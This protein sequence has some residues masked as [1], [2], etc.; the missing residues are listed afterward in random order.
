[1][2]TAGLYILAVMNY[3]I[4]RFI[5][6]TDY[7]TKSDEYKRK[8]KHVRFF[9]GIIYLIALSVFLYLITKYLLGM[10]FVEGFL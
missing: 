8:M 6:G 7:E 10:L 5:T 9:V 4:M 1:M 3:K 2:L